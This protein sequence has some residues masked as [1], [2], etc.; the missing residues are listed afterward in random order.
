MKRL[1]FK[2]VII[3][4]LLICTV[5]GGVA[6]FT[7]TN[8]SKKENALQV[9]QLNKQKA[10]E[11]RADD[12]RVADAKAISDAKAK[13]DAKAIEDAKVKQEAN[14]NTQEVVEKRVYIKMHEMINSKIVSADGLRYGIQDISPT[15]CD[16]LLK[17]IKVNNYTDKDTLVVFLNSWKKNDFSKGVEQHNYLWGKLGGGEGKAVSL[18]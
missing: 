1:K 17:I 11:K 14:L 7:I 18:K 15:V 3:P 10:D 4:I 9:I 8:K 16:E 12:K 5:V 13:A 6:Y 2:T